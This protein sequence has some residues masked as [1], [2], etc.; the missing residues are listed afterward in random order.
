MMHLYTIVTV[1][2]G[3]LEDIVNTQMTVGPIHVLL[4]ECVLMEVT[5][6]HVS[7]LLGTVEETVRYLREQVKIVE[8]LLKNQTMIEVEK[9]DC[10]ILK[11]FYNI[12]C[13][14]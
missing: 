1:P 14:E 2:Q 11:I 10:F 6:S 5:T 7:V 8:D 12:V 4:I 13:L 9:T 3:M